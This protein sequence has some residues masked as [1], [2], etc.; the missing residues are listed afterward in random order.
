LQRA[1]TDARFQVTVLS[2]SSARAQTL[3][4]GGGWRQGRVVKFIRKSRWLTLFAYWVDTNLVRPAGSG[5]SAAVRAAVIPVISGF[6]TVVYYFRGAAPRFTE[7]DKLVRAELDQGRK[8]VLLFAHDY[9]AIPTLARFGAEFAQQPENADKFALV[10]PNAT[11]EAALK[12]IAGSA[13]IINMQRFWLDQSIDIANHDAVNKVM[14]GIRAVRD[15]RL[16]DD[17]RRFDLF[18]SMTMDLHIELVLM[19]RLAGAMQAAVDEGRETIAVCMHLALDQQWCCQEVL[20]SDSRPNVSVLST[21]RESEFM[22]HV[23]DGRPSVAKMI[24]RARKRVVSSSPEADTTEKSRR[25]HTRHRDP[26]RVA[27]ISDTAPGT[28]FWPTV[29]NLAFASKD[30]GC[31]MRGL[32]DNP[33]VANELRK[34]G[35]KVDEFPRA[36]DAAITPGFGK[37]YAELLDNLEAATASRVDGDVIGNAL[38]DHVITRLAYSGNDFRSVLVNYRTREKVEEWLLNN[39]VG[40]IVVA[41]HWGRLAWAAAAAATALDIPCSSTPAVSVAGNS[42]SIVG[43]NWLALVGCY[44]MQCK[45]A[46]LAL[47]YPPERL[48]LTGSVGLDR[49]LQFPQAQARLRLGTYANLAE[50]GR[51]VVLYATSGVNK[52]EREVLAKVIEFCRNPDAEAALVIRPHHSIGRSLY[53]E[54]VTAVLG[55]SA[56]RRAVVTAEGT[57]HDNIIAADIVITDFSTIGAEAVLLGRPLLVINTTGQPFPANNYAD[58][59][60]AVQASSLDEINP[61][62][63]R[64][65]D[66]GAFWPNARESVEA[67]TE[68][69]NWGGGQAGKRLLGALG[70]LADD[71]LMRVNPNAEPSLLRPGESPSWDDDDVPAVEAVPDGDGS[72]H[73]DTAQDQS[74]VALTSQLPPL[75]EIARASVTS[76]DV[77]AF[78]IQQGTSLRD[79]IALIDRNGSGIA[80]VVDPAMRLLD[81]VTDGDIRRAI[82]GGIA[83]TE[84][85]SKVVEAKTA[86]GKVHKPV[87]GRIEDPPEFLLM[88]MERLVLHQLPLL[89]REGRVK[90]IVHR[91]ALS[92]RP[93]V[94]PGTRAVVMAGGFGTR[95]R[96][97]TERIPKPMLKVAGRPILEHSVRRLVLAGFDRIFITLHYLPE[98]ITDHFGDGSRF[99]TKIEYVNETT[100]LGTAGSVALTDHGGS[101]MLIMNGDVMTDLNYVALMDFHQATEA[102]ITMAGAPYEVGVPYGVVAIDDT[103]NV[104]GLQEKPIQRFY[105]NTGIYVASPAALGLI[106]TNTVYNMTDLVEEA[107]R[108]GLRAKLYAMHEYWRDIGRIE[109]LQRAN[110]EMGQDRTIR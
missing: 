69:Y 76:D 4:Q 54:T 71:A 35:I 43:W 97:L 15:T 6:F 25:D 21:T 74:A 103:N 92:A 44:G 38:Q 91:D 61:L 86:D 34:E 105:I 19:M 60:V 55:S 106:P 101:P 80:V 37:A 1:V 98:V 81:V 13:K 73:V 18:E 41:P 78:A 29:V 24:E 49:V 31:A 110:L 79:T 85:V 47:G 45:E 14:N 52:N 70:K 32:V 22:F 42:A 109:D 95:L 3:A 88:L 72:A 100:P 51:R 36:E 56:R 94:K 2:D 68:A 84:P 93:L 77:G 66:E 8:P 39:R 27:L 64:L 104:T 108:S 20:K 23:P 57:A 17:S 62:L 46:F 89:D 63:F 99:G 30:A 53:E 96:P 83:L 58:L 40:A 87:A 7:A 5:L 75:A 11:V 107:I 28:H 26:R 59:G 102:A 16:S 67:F 50:G 12:P 65:R 90:R 48:Q 10:V 82:L 9:L 33:A